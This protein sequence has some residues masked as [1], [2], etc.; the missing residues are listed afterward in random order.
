MT[1][2]EAFRIG[3]VGLALAFGV[4]GQA[5]AL[6][7][8]T[9]DTKNDPASAIRRVIEQQLD[10][11][12]KDDAERAFSFA[13]PNIRRAFRDADTFMAL[14]MKDYAPM[15]RWQAA[16]FLDL[17]TYEGHYVQRVKLTDN[18]GASSVANYALIKAATGEWWVAG[19]AMEDKD[20]ASKTE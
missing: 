1:V 19:V 7:Q 9:L 16:T 10:A 17:R 14:V 3:L 18:K 13:S 5:H 11:I 2:A 20:A 4:S 15:R 8:A 12:R 6:G